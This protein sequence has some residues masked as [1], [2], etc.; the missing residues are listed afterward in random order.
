VIQ[1]AAPQYRQTAQRFMTTR[2]EIAGVAL[3]GSVGRNQEWKKE[4]GE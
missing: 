1:L 4:I 2:H 3:E